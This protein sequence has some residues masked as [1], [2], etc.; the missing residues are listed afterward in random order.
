MCG[1]KFSDPL[2]KH[3][4][5]LSLTVN[6]DAAHSNSMEGADTHGS[7]QPPFTV[8]SPQPPFTV[9]KPEG[10]AQAEAVAVGPEAITPISSPREHVQAFEFL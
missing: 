5:S 9:S 2:A 4:A 1:L 10:P 7:P 3:T 8:G 6:R